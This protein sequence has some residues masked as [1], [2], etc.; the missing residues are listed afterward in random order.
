M[1]ITGQ[2][3]T[4]ESKTERLSYQDEGAVIK[5]KPAFK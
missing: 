2:P 5:K 3:F 1:K 4:I